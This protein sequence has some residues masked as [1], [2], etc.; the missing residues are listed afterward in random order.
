M[1][2][3][4]AL[5]LLAALGCPFAPPPAAVAA[6]GPP[7]TFA[8]LAASAR[9]TLAAT[10]YAGA[11]RWRTCLAPACPAVHSDWGADAL[12]YALFLRW[13][14]RPDAQLA[15]IF[16]ALVT[17]APVYDA[18]R[19][20]A[21]RTWSDVPEWDAI[22]ALRMFRVTADPRALRRAEAA[23]WSVELS[24]AFALG[25]C[26]EVRYQHPF[27]GGGGLKTLETD[28]NSVKA[29]LLLFAATHDARYLGA[30]RRRYRAIRR[31]FL[32]ASLALYTVY[33]LDDG[34]RCRQIP[35]RFFAS[36]NG[37]MIW[38]GLALARATGDSRYRRDAFATAH[39]VDRLL[40]D[41]RGVFANLQ[42]END[43]AEPLVEAMA[44]VAHVGGGSFAGAWVARNA[45]AAAANA[46]R[47][48]GTY[49]RFADGPAPTAPATAWQTNG[50]LALA[51]AAG[52]LFPHR[53]VAPDASW[54]RSVRS[55]V[56]LATFPA[57]VHVRGTGV[58]LI[59]TLGERCCEG[60]HA[61]VFVDG[62]ETVDGTGIWQNKSSAGRPFPGS[63]LF[64]WRWS[65]RGDHIV[66]LRAGE[67]NPKEGGPFVRVTREQV[68][69]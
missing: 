28:A 67:P 26:P 52:A 36:V 34:A 6:S 29:A 65:S 59:G 51:I 33:V 21:C 43:V 22:A 7:A 68:I 11:G 63:V 10:M 4:A 47:A 35:R 45:E 41:G 17:T 24:D 42:A 48:D 46:R 3:A 61:R 8:A 31:R 13:E 66:E 54:S 40:A 14:Q 30:A 25:A 62:R 1:T 2:R 37:D 55:T 44:S 38:S 9:H 15:A 57:R 50:G 64:A 19:G 69:P 27:G 23:F 49:G 60:G 32:D 53:V 20:R 18:C 16:R 56:D 12:T 39:A 58:A 5:L